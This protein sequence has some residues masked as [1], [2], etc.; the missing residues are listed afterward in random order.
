SA[1]LYFTNNDEELIERVHGYL[2]RIGL[3]PTVRSPH[4]G[5]TASEVYAS[6]IELY[7][8]LEWLRI[9]G[10]S[11]E[12]RISPQLFNARDVDIKAFLR[13]Y[14]DAKG[15]VDKRRPKITIV[16]ASKELV[17]GI[18]H[19]LLRFSIKSQFHETV[20]KATNGKM[21]E[22]KTYYRLFITGEDAA[23]FRDIVGFGLPRKM[24]VLREV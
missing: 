9:A 24:E 7:S 2:S 15:T 3:N 11:A 5:K 4:K 22:K 18:Q 10:N 17:R 16:S 20:S 14:F 1:T 12:K 23:K 21:K 13:G 8:L 6:G 19:L